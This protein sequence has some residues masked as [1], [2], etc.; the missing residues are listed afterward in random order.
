M[1]LLRNVRN[2]TGK[3]VVLLMGEMSDLLPP[4]LQKFTLDKW[5]STVDRVK[6]SL[7]EKGEMEKYNEFLNDR[8]E[9]VTVQIFFTLF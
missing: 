6:N 7:Y 5:I 2:A 8:I 1:G 9:E 4:D 3:V